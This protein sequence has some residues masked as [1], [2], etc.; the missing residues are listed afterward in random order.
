[1][2]SQTRCVEGRRL[3]RL[4][5]YVNHTPQARAISCVRNPQVRAASGATHAQ[6][7]LP[8][9][10]RAGRDHRQSVRRLRARTAD[11]ARSVRHLWSERDTPHETVPCLRD[12]AAA[13]RSYVVRARIFVAGRLPRR[14]VEISSG[15]ARSA[16]T[17]RG[18]P[19]AP[20]PPRP[21][22]TGS[23]RCLSP[24]HACASAGS[25]RHSRL[26]APCATVPGFASPG[27]YAGDAVPRLLNRHCPTPLRGAR[28][29]RASS[30]RVPPSGAMSS[31]S[32]T[33]SPPE[34]R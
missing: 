26:R 16:G 21:A 24:R 3:T 13:S 8:A 30:E 23:L 20:S 5:M 14:A 27:W 12:T 9:L 33:W 15:L 19:F 34:L 10:R 32:T 22:S 2:G 1:M 7:H 28:T 11:A 17:R 25:T 6:R 4:E 18:P 29:S 31:S